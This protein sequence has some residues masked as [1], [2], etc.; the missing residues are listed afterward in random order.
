MLEPFSAI[1][2]RRRALHTD[3]NG[4]M[5]LRMGAPSQVGLLKALTMSN[6]GNVMVEDVGLPVNWSDKDIPFVDHAKLKD[7][8]VWEGLHT[9]MKQGIDTKLVV[10]NLS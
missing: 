2:L 3:E 7:G 8:S 6:I 9:I 4:R 1:V 5:Y 10:V